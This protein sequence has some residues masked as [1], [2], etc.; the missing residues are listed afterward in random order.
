MEEDGL[1]TVTVSRAGDTLFG[2]GMD[3]DNIVDAVAE[4]S[5]SAQAGLLVGD[6]VVSVNGQRLGARKLARWLAETHATLIK[7]GIERGGAMSQKETAVAVNQEVK[8]EEREVK[9]ED[10]AL[11][12]RRPAR[13]LKPVRASPA[14]RAA[15]RRVREDAGLLGDPTPTLRGRATRCSLTRRG[16]RPTCRTAAWTARAL[17]AAARRR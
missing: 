12:H 16:R 1:L 10:E 15:C 13:T 5:S 9:Q 2:L 6:K 4:G 8:Q 14:P 7:L 3:N 11:A 17:Q